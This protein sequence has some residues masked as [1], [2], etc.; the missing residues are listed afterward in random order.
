[1]QRIA[2]V[3]RALGHFVFR[4]RDYLAPVALALI[5]ACA[6]SSDF[7]VHPRATRLLDV[8]GTGLLVAGLLI[9]IAVAGYGVVRRSGRDRRISASRLVTGG[10]YAHARNPLYV[11][12]VMILSGVAATYHSRTVLLVGL[13]LLVAAVVAMVAAEERFLAERFGAEYAAYRRRVRR[14]L[15]SVAG[16]GATLRRTPFDAKRSL[17][18]EYGPTFAVVAT[19]LLLITRR[20]IALAGLAAASRDLTDVAT[21]GAVCA[22]AYACVRWLKKTK[23]L[24][25]A[26]DDDGRQLVPVAENAAGLGWQ[27]DRPA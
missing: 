13:P 3:Y 16:L 10:L 6:R 21:V 20:R 27:G 8:V 4:Y 24:E 23:R 12:N 2:A 17:R 22:L 7:V 5:V 9:R 1:M 14:Y 15:P 26:P 18:R 19:T 11:A 25:T